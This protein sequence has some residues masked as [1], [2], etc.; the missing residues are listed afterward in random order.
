[1]NG[2]LGGWTILPTLR[3][4]SGSPFS[5]GNVQLV[6][7]TVKELQHEIGVRKGPNVVTYLPD[8]IILNTQRAFNID[9]TNTA[10]NGYGTTFGT[11]GPS[12]RFLAPAGYGNC[13]QRNVGECGFSNLID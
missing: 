10:N 1:V 7:M 5:F 8:D 6:G 2:V 9:V 12:G 13:L 11:G 3:W 4:Q